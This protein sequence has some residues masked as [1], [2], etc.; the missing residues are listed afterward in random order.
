ME[1]VN[2]LLQKEGTI[3]GILEG[4]GLLS[5]SR[6]STRTPRKEVAAATVTAAGP[7]MG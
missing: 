7:S 5:E 6:R 3:E 4:A 1:V 2:I